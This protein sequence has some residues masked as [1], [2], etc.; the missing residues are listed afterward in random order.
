M[1]STSSLFQ[2]CT[3]RIARFFGLFTV[4]P[5]AGV[6]TD[7]AA[8]RKTAGLLDYLGFAPSRRVKRLT[9]WTATWGLNSIWV[10]TLSYISYICFHHVFDIE[11]IPLWKEILLHGWFYFVGGLLVIVNIRLAI[12]RCRDIGWTPWLVLPFFLPLIIAC[13]S[14]ATGFKELLEYL[15]FYMNPFGLIVSGIFLICLLAWGSETEEGAPR[16]SWKVFA[17]SVLYL[18]LLWSLS[19]VFD[20]LRPLIR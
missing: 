1:T 17:A 8:P 7:S 2:R 4:A 5:V 10:V 12:Q 15:A 18:P 9:Y 11:N 16:G 14:I 19:F 20:F 3:K 6:E 13:L